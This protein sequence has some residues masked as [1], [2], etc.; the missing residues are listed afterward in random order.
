MIRNIYVNA[1]HKEED[2]IYVEYNNS[3]AVSRFS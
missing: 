3:W 2:K 1:I